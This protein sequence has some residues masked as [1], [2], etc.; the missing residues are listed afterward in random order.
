[1]LNMNAPKVCALH[2]SVFKTNLFGT[3]SSFRS[4]NIHTEGGKPK[5]C[6]TDE[7]GDFWEIFAET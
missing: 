4:L 6:I 5:L 3:R 7:N 1:M 2:F